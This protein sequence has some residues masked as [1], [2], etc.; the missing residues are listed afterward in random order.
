ML[1]LQCCCIYIVFIIT[2]SWPPCPVQEVSWKGAKPGSYIEQ[3]HI[4]KTLVTSPIFA[5]KF[6]FV[7]VTVLSICETMAVA[8]LS[9]SG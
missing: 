5:S 7:N 3:I 9:G 1:L 2:E 6:T 4:S 8:Q